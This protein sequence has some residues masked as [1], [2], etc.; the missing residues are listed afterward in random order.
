MSSPGLRISEV[1]AATGSTGRVRKVRPQA[2][3]RAEKALFGTGAKLVAGMDEVGR[4]A[5]AGPVTVGVTLVSTETG[6]CP[7][8][9]TDS[10][11]L[12]ATQRE[13]HEITSRQWCKAWGVGH[14]QP[15][16]I[17]QIGITGALR[18]AGLRAL[19]Q[20]QRLVGPIDALL[21]DGSHDW[22]SAPPADLFSTAE[23]D[24]ELSQAL[25][26]A[27]VHTV[28]KGDETCAS[29]SAA[30]VLAK[31]ARDRIMIG[32]ADEYPQYGWSSNKGYGAAVHLAALRA[33]GPSA[34][35]RLSWRLPAQISDGDGR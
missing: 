5:L 12:S 10:K 18:R 31:C 16:E 34:V 8:G 25:A 9:L 21:L 22:L 33:V 14:A 30:S 19:E 35:H 28:V 2:D 29:I 6:P 20:A 7:P 32:L 24:D 13:A 11:W 3:L 15:L 1:T 17:D 26:G 23:E 27:A 4:G